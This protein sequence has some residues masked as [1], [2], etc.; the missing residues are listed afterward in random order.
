MPATGKVMAYP[1]RQAHEFFAEVGV[2]IG[3]ETYTFRR[4]CNLDDDACPVFEHGELEMRVRLRVEDIS[5]DADGVAWLH[6]S[7]LFS[8]G[9]LPQYVV[10]A[11]SGFDAQHELAES[12]GAVQVPAAEVLGVCRVLSTSVWR[13]LSSEERGGVCHQEAAFVEEDGNL[14]KWK[15]ARAKTR[16]GCDASAPQRR[17]RRR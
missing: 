7:C 11:L 8:S 10:G 12:I 16:E 1:E 6:G 2:Q 4:S 14:A 5:R 3:D 13:A 15:A 9:Q 17:A